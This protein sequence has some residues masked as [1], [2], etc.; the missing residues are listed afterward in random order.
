MLSWLLLVLAIW[1]LCVC[2]ICEFI[3]IFSVAFLLEMSG[4]LLNGE[5]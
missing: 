5:V 4:F 3:Q 2:C 1:Y